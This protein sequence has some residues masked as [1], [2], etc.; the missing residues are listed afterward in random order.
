MQQQ[1]QIAI[2]LED[3]QQEITLAAI[4]IK[5]DSAIISLANRVRQLETSQAE[6]K[7]SKKDEKV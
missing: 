2:N 3:L 1:N 7:E 4:I 6:A 5:R